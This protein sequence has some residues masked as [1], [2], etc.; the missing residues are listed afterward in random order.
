[1]S[2]NT[3]VLMEMF[4]NLELEVLQQVVKCLAKELGVPHDVLW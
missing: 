1:M 3:R 4:A 2:N